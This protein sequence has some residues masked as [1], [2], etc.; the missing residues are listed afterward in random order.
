MD[1]VQRLIAFVVLSALSGI[2]AAAQSYAWYSDFG[3]ATVRW[4]GYS[5]AQ[6]SCTAS[7]ADVSANYSFAGVKPF[8]TSGNT[9]ICMA[10]RAPD[11]AH[12]E[13][14]RTTR[15]LWNCPGTQVFQ[16]SI[17]NCGD[18][19]PECTGGQTL[20]PVTNKCESKCTGNRP[21][22]PSFTD[23]GIRCIQTPTGPCQAEAT[24]RVGSRGT[25]YR[26]VDTGKACSNDDSPEPEK[27]GDDGASESC[28][29]VTCAPKSD[30]SCKAGY[31]QGSINGTTMCVRDSS[32]TKET[33]TEESGGKS[34]S[35]QEKTECKGENCTTTKTTTTSNADGTTST[36]TSTS[37]QG[38][39][40]YCAD[41][42]R[43]KACSDGDETVWGG[44]C[45]SA[46]ICEGDAIQ[47]AMAREQHRRN[48]T[49]FEDKS[50]A[51]AKLGENSATQEAQPD[52]HPGKTPTDVNVSFGSI[53]QTNP[54]GTGCP[55]DT[56]VPVFGGSFV[57]P[58]SQTCGALKF[59]GYT[60]VAASLLVAAR[61]TLEGV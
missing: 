4:T 49:I 50:S 7:L 27:K 5:S 59:L 42:P 31:S 32:D 16:E 35:T 8:G 55:I 36:D 33:T 3:S 48:C 57:I 37:T 14:G 13:P 25:T 9:V 40:S 41:N 34:S 23:V 12:A 15:S 46:F 54:Y 44:S 58:W 43:A 6:A 18:A 56:T 45:Q 53:D 52:G 20:N 2:A 21:L 30:G 10:T 51:I 26:Y 24:I 17:Q 1:L 11:G 22:G 47:C 39:D 60:L 28:T 61:I 29:G 38:K 19:P